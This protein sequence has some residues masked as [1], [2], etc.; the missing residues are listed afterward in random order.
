MFWQTNIEGRS[1]A[2]VAAEMG[3]TTDAVYQAKSRVARRLRA[4]F[5]KIV[6]F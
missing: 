2:D 4:V 6:A 3:V 1:A 5:A